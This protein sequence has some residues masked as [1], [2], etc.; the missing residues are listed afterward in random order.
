MIWCVLVSAALVGVDQLVKHWAVLHLKGQP[1]LVIWEGVFQLTYAENTGA[2]FSALSWAG[3]PFF[4][5]LGS[6]CCALLLL[7][8]W[9]TSRYPFQ[10]TAAR[11]LYICGVL[12]LSGAAGNMVDRFRTG[13]VVDL[14][15]FILIHFAIF[16]VADICLTV[17]VLVLIVEF[18]FRK[19][20]F[21]KVEAICLRKK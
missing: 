3:R 13:Y 12:I 1:S 11:V 4:L 16:N 15:D 21:T 18:L 20:L 8:L 6:I 19:G 14:F 9:R 2:A 10:N 7:V 5:T 17:G